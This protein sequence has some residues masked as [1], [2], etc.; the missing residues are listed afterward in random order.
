MTANPKT[1]KDGNK[2]GK[3]EYNISH[4]MATTVEQISLEC[5]KAIMKNLVNPSEQEWWHKYPKCCSKL[6]NVRNDSSLNSNFNTN[7]MDC[8]WDDDKKGIGRRQSKSFFECESTFKGKFNINRRKCCAKSGSMDDVEYNGYCTDYNYLKNNGLSGSSASTN[9]R[10]YK[11][12]KSDKNVSTGSGI[13]G[14]SNQRV[15]DHT[16]YSLEI[17]PYS[18][19]S[20]STDKCFE[21]CKKII[22]DKINQ[23]PSDIDT[24]TQDECITFANL[25]NGSPEKLNLTTTHDDDSMNW[26]P[27]PDQPRGCVLVGNK[28]YWNNDTKAKGNCGKDGRPCIKIKKKI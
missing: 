22:Y 23:G 2:S 1:Y 3:I 17:A 26:G 13:L 24:M 19:K 16:K 27:H 20:D 5:S 10:K 6:R 21:E 12:V 9:Q 7:N 4:D 18:V 15:I 11:L 14:D 8:S 28:I 25:P